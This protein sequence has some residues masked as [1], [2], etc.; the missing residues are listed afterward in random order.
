M[1]TQMDQLQ[2][3][4]EKLQKENSYLKHKWDSARQI[5]PSAITMPNPNPYKRGTGAGSP[6]KGSLNNS[7]NMIEKTK[8]SSGT[9]RID[10]MVHEY[11]K[12]NNMHA[13]KG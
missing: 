12:K 3:I 4:N 10:D 13:A 11:K 6:D 8:Q 7:Q 1:S 5:S 9:K 2:E